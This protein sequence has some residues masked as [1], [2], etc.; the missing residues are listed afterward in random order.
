MSLGSQMGNWFGDAVI[1][2]T[3]NFDKAKQAIKQFSIQFTQ[4]MKAAGTKAGE[5]AGDEAVKGLHRSLLKWFGARTMGLAVIKTG[6]M[7]VDLLE[8][9][10]EMEKRLGKQT[11]QWHDY[12][13]AVGS[14]IPV[15][16]RVY[17]S[18]KKLAAMAEGTDSITSDTNQWNETW[19]KGLEIGEAAKIR[20]KRS[21]LKGEELAQFDVDLKYDGIR[22]EQEA[23]RQQETAAGTEAAKRRLEEAKKAK[24]LYVEHNRN[25][26]MNSE[27][28]E[29]TLF[30]KGTDEDVIKSTKGNM[31]WNE[32]GMTRAQI[33]SKRRDEIARLNAE[34]TAATGGVKNVEQAI[35]LKNQ[36]VV[37]NI[38]LA[39]RNEKA[40]IKKHWEEMDEKERER[41]IK[42]QD[43]EAKKGV[44]EERKRQQPLIDANA[45]TRELNAKLGRK[46][47]VVEELRHTEQLNE[48]ELKLLET[49]NKQNEAL[50]KRANAQEAAKNKAKSIEDEGR[51][52]EFRSLG[53][54]EDKIEIWKAKRDGVDA[55][56]ITDLEAA[57]A[58]RRRGE[59]EKRKA[60]LEIEHDE[61]N[62]T[63]EARELMELARQGA[64]NEQLKPLADLLTQRE[65]DNRKKFQSEKIGVGGL[66]DSIQMKL[67]NDPL[68]E[69]KRAAD[70]L[71]DIKNNGIKVQN[72]PQAAAVGP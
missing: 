34:I 8:N 7:F 23:Q 63:P 28:G 54:S 27:T 61:K 3:A 29:R 30:D 32:L 37:D 41:E 19:A 56:G 52:D 51:F 71:E 16:G 22:R 15:F 21:G 70:A 18:M 64:T 45:K 67:L 40:T 69:Q 26:F 66:N 49:V 35:D 11:A 9:L 13:D 1:Y 33:E 39:K 65:N 6:E 62:M 60:D 25:Q 50:Q 20:A 12:V 59:I 4:E 17:E 48:E 72:L 55:K 47:S 10:D 68:R 38:E 44:D 24:E 53:M 14:S 58:R 57:Q 5:E 36:G 31:N 46:D 2:I 43:D 42:Q